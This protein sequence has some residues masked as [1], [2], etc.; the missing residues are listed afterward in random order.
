MADVFPRGLARRFEPVRPVGRGGMGTVFEA[1][2]GLLGRRVAVKVLT[3]YGSVSEAAAR[4]FEGEARALARI[5]HPNVVGVYDA[6]IDEGTPYLVMEFLDGSDI[7]ALVRTAGPLPVAEACRI[8][9]DTLAG[10][11]AA[12]RS[13]VLHRDVKPANIRLT[14]SGRVVLYDFGLARLTGEAA[15][16]NAG[17]LLGTPQYM[18]PER[19]RGQWPLAASD[20][21]GVGAC[22]HFMLTGEPP[23]GEAHRVDVLL[24]RVTREG[25]PSLREGPTVWP[26][27]LADAV[28]ALSA[29]DV[30]SRVPTAGAAEALIRPWA[31]EGGAAP[32]RAE[33]DARPVDHRA[34]GTEVR[35]L[36]NHAAGTEIG[37]LDDH[38]S[39]TEV[40]PLDDHA[41][42]ESPEALDED[43]SVG[44]PEYDWG[45]VD[46]RPAPV[47][48]H[49]SGHVTLSQS[50]RRLVR[51]RM[52][53]QTALSR[54]REAVG[55]IQRG[56]LR[57][58]LDL[59][60][61]IGPFCTQT[62]GP[63][64][65]TTLACQYWQAVCLARLGR[66]PQ[67]LELFARVSAHNG[68]GR[69]TEDV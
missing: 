59:L 6:G 24:D 20:V 21:Y 8:A 66:A 3:V 40:R 60:V 58:A 41:L 51:S 49:R 67:A 36:D 17:D 15:L 45:L 55:L 38:A 61:G 47:P 27:A 16:T 18:A 25:L 26:E 44:V 64:H 34:S 43:D 57:E 11:G 13:G 56:N 39:A 30:E 46:V 12:H 1:E 7:S 31:G 10:L 29:R 5:N 28:D 22:L 52:T 53:G 68:Q 14:A 42:G 9:A 48:A 63:A 65:P 54:Q 2:D 50:T 35:P 33:V 62:L 32:D 19:I 23:F 4:R 37:A 69:G